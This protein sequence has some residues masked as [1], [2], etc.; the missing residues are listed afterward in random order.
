MVL[1]NFDFCSTYVEIKHP[2]KLIK[3]QAL[4]PSVFSTMKSKIVLKMYPPIM[5]EVTTVT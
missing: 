2:T 1:T 5:E 4:T 3:S